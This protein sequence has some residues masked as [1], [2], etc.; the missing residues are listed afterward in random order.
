MT[1]A[2]RKLKQN[3]NKIMRFN[4]PIARLAFIVLLIGCIA[5]LARA[6]E[7]NY[8]SDPTK[9]LGP[10][11]CAECHAPMVEAWKM[12]HHYDTFTSMHRRPEARE[13]ANK[14][15]MR[16]IKEESL[17]LKCH[18]TAQT[19]DDGSVKAISG[20]SCESCHGAAR[21]WNKVHSATNDPDALVKAAK[22]GMLQP[23]NYYAVAANCFGCHTVPE[24]KLVNVGGHK[25]GSDFELVSWVSGE[26]R[27]NLQ[28]SAGK[29]NAPIP[30]ARQRMLFIT[31]R[32]LDLEFGLRG[33]ARATEDG[34]YS[35]AMLARVNEAKGHL[36][37]I[38]KDANLPEV[39]GMLDAVAAGDLKI[40]NE[41]AIAK[42]ADTVS[43]NARKLADSNDGSKLASIDSLIPGPDKYKG[44]PYQ[45]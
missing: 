11:T 13:I 14:M 32:A 42:M 23:S 19:Q 36:E 27:H 38:Q 21:D 35:K 44:T 25:A 34:I 2:Q 45:P 24:E 30:V 28:K 15:G 40:N 26:V 7:N 39:K 5:P 43:E 9:I 8:H 29:V 12:T 33:L 31:G 37:E 1:E 3:G 41:A 6:D 18:Y 17:C 16:R 20:I 10:E 22:L 4:L